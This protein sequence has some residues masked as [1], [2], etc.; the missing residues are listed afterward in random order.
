MPAVKTLT[1][2]GAWL[3]CKYEKRRSAVNAVADNSRRSLNLRGNLD[4]VRYERPVYFQFR[5]FGYETSR[6]ACN[7]TEY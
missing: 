1:A 3:I 4:T 6:M 5:F 2:F 7:S